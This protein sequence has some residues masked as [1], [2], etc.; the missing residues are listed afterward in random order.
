MT[1]PHQI[2]VAFS[3]HRGL[4]QRHDAREREMD[5][6]TGF[7][8]VTGAQP[9]TWHRVREHTEALEIYPDDALVREVADLGL[10]AAPV[11][12]TLGIDDPV[13]FGLASLLRRAHLGRDPLSDVRAS[14]IGVRLVE[15]LVG[16]YSDLRLPF[17]RFKGRLD[18]GRLRRVGELVADRLGGPVTIPAMAAAAGLSAAHFSR[19]FKR[20]TGLSPQAYVNARRMTAAKN[21]LMTSPM[22]VDDVAAAVGLANRSH[23]RRLF[24]A[25]FGVAPSA[26]RN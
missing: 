3:E 18:A 26:L 9:I 8:F 20:S 25:T 14:E 22:T 19:A 1:R 10:D 16:R 2:G 5:V 6:R 17:E 21:L 23:F 4:V 11:R 7:A 13:V 12:P 24:R 15:H